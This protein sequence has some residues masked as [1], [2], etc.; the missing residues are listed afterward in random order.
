L[1]FKLV[2]AE[3]TNEETDEY[4][5][6]IGE[7]SDLVKFTEGLDQLPKGI[8]KQGAEKVAKWLTNK[9]GL[10]VIADGENLIVPTLAPS[11]TLDVEPMESDMIVTM[12]VGECIVAVGLMLATTGFPLAKLLKL[13]KTIELLGGVTKTVNRIYTYYQ[14]YR[15]WN[16]TKSAAWKRA[17][18]DA[19]GS[20]SSDAKLVF[21][22]FFNLGNVYNNCY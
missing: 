1:T 4:L 18:S 22:E 15:S 2:N 11:T 19:G 14:K 7:D 16:Y 13:K 10:E 9:T 6:L 3:T 21:L 17:V 8:E 20:L 12:G 5:E